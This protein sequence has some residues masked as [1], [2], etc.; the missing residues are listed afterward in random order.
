MPLPRGVLPD[1]LHHPCVDRDTVGVDA[2][3][4]EIEPV[5]LTAGEVALQRFS[6]LPAAQHGLSLQPRIGVLFEMFGMIRVRVNVEDLLRHEI[7]QVFLHQHPVS[8]VKC[9]RDLHGKGMW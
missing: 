2:G 3:Q 9:R 5:N 4:T 8:I 7:A 6:M 1:L